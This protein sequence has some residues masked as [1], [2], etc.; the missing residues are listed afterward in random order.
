M[1]RLSNVTFILLALMLPNIATSN[2]GII[3]VP[4]K[5]EQMPAEKHDPAEKVAAT[6]SGA[7]ISALDDQGLKN[8]FELKEQNERR[9]KATILAKQR[10]DAALKE[11]PEAKYASVVVLADK[12]LKKDDSPGKQANDN[13]NFLRDLLVSSAKH[14]STKS[15]VLRPIYGYGYDAITVPDDPSPPGQSKYSH[16]DITYI[17]TRNPDGSITTRSVTPTDVEEHYRDEQ[18]SL[19]NGYTESARLAEE[20]AKNAQDEADRKEKERKAEDDRKKAEQAKKNY[21]ALKKNMDARDE[22]CKKG[23]AACREANEKLMHK[24]EAVEKFNRTA[25]CIDFG[26]IDK[27]P[28]AFG[29]CSAGAPPCMY[30][31]HA[32][33]FSNKSKLDA[34]TKKIFSTLKKLGSEISIQ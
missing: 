6:K 1:N 13:I 17:A 23:A 20:K 15:D 16:R 10:L 25:R 2:D 22:S 11:N 12:P 30:C 24:F 21:E 33:D 27:A 19:Y 29:P 3:L 7:G 34:Q 18:L 9:E 8:I 14:G 26:A 32:K 4:D 5:P 31:S 28:P